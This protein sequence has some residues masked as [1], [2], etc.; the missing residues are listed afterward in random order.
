MNLTDLTPDDIQIEIG[1]LKAKGLNPKTIRNAH[2]LINAVIS[3]YRPNLRLNT[4]LPQKIPYEANIFTETEMMKVWQAAKGN[5]FEL[6]ILFASWLGLRM[7]EYF[8][9]SNR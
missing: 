1:K 7:S 8:G 6:P 4:K 5:E 2:G 9:S 3:T